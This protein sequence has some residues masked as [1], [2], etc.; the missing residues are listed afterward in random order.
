MFLK[1]SDAER[2]LKRRGFKKRKS[3]SSHRIWTKPDTA[4]I[5]FSERKELLS[6][7]IRELSKLLDLDERDLRDSSRFKQIIKE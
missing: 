4:T 7:A 6:Y 1:T 2:L 5:V 3:R